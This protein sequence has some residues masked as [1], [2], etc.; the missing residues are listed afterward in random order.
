ML[1]T[2]RTPTGTIL[3]YW[4]MRSHK[5]HDS[6]AI[7]HNKDTYFLVQYAHTIGTQ[8]IDFARQGV[9]ES[10]QQSNN[11]SHSASPI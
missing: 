10:N 11:T 9:G 3:S 1:A 6:Y 7:Y 2:R 4:N 5:N 8:N